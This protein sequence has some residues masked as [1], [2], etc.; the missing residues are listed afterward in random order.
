MCRLFALHADAP[1][2][3]EFWLLDAPYSLRAQ[4]RFNAD[5]TG[6]GHIDEEGRSHVRKRPVAA[7]AS[8]AFARAAETV[9]ART[10]IA[11][12]RLSSGTEH[13]ARNTHPFL[14]DGIILAHNGVLEVTQEMR[15][16]VARLGA[17]RHVHGATDSEW[18]A[19]L[20][21]GETAAH[22]GD[23]HAGLVA[24]VRW[25][26]AHAPVYSL[27]L[28][29]ARGEDLFALRLPA[30]NELWVLERPAR[31]DPARGRPVPAPP[32]SGEPRALHAP[33]RGTVEH[34]S[35]AF[36]A[37]SA[38]L[39]GTRSVVIASEPMDDDPAWRLLEVGELL[40]IGADG[41]PRSSR[42]FP[43][44]AHP[45]SIGDLNLSAATSQ[46]HAA[47]DRAHAERRARL[48]AARPSSA[49]AVPA[50]THGIP[51]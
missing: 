36:A 46:M 4:S 17:A 34:R 28:L 24:A 48:A 38:D 6:L 41:V 49:L 30:A 16:R 43:P 11:H 32:T 50:E 35:D 21:A 51:A 39:A 15:R 14:M 18:L 42:P 37:R 5:G 31:E 8:E 33:L 23:L 47:Q 2:T 45:L 12:L 40:S 3:A 9:T 44:L 29:A 1:V 7:Y 27:N 13:T 19:A 22:A 25:V 20:I 26:A 10:I